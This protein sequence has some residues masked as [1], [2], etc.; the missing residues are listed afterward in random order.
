MRHIYKFIDFPLS[1]NLSPLDL[2]KAIFKD[3]YP[4]AQKYSEECPFSYC[5]MY[6]VVNPDK[7]IRL[8]FKYPQD[9][10]MK[11]KIIHKNPH[12][13]IV[14]QP[15]NNTEIREITD[16]Y[17]PPYDDRYYFDFIVFILD[18]TT[19][20][21]WIGN[22]WTQKLCPD[23]RFYLSKQRKKQYLKIGK[24]L[25]ENYNSTFM[26]GYVNLKSNKL[27]PSIGIK[28]LINNGWIPTFCF[29][30]YPYIEMI[31]LIESNNNISDV[32]N[33]IN[34][35][36]DDNPNFINDILARWIATSLAKDRKDILQ[37]AIK[38]FI[39]VD[40][41][42]PI[43]LLLPQIEGLI[44][45]HIKRKGHTPEEDLEKRFLQFEEIIN[46][47]KYNT[48][49]TLYL[50]NKLV[51]HLKKA[52]FKK[53]FPFPKTYKRVN[54]TKIYRGSTI[55]PQRH[56]ILHGHVNSNYYTKEN[57]LK[58]IGIIDAIVL[59]S[60]RKSELPASMSFK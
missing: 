17:I 42:S 6:L 39:S 43:Y 23:L 19:Q 14:G 53:W 47:E 59:L 1:S 55:C 10:Q 9:F 33:N 60:L 57:C 45:E 32:E 7:T 48:K 12:G 35:F 8:D 5:I 56:V 38:N 13:C 21:Y 11:M 34:K 30:P 50:A 2:A 29:F 46:N 16:I 31:R 49:F 22:L 36:I 24:S 41:I 18:I 27:R 3:K 4:I 26:L 25:A 54:I 28:R 20:K 37:T 58:L 51:T 52:Y 40:Y 15:I 44:T